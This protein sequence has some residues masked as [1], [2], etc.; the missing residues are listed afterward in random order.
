MEK[1]RT[2]H[3]KFLFERT[4][5]PAVARHFWINNGKFEAIDLVEGKEITLPS[6]LIA[7]ITRCDY[8]YDDIETGQEVVQQR[9]QFIEKDE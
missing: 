3:F 9:F 2:G 8:Q 4:P 7:N 5:K 6:D 1:N